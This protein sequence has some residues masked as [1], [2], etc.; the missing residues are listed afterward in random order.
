LDAV[1]ESVGTFLINTNN[2]FLAASRQGGLPRPFT[3]PLYATRGTRQGYNARFVPYFDSSDH[4]TFVEGIIGVPAV[5]TINWD[6][7]YIHSTDDDL[8]QIDQTQLRRNIF[9]IGSI[10]YYLSRATEREIPALAAE[11]FA[12]GQRRLANDLKVALEILREGKAQAPESWKR[13]RAV[14]EQ[15]TLREQRALQSIVA[16]TPDRG[17]GVVASAPNDMLARTERREAELASDL[18]AAFRQLHG[19]APAP[20]TL[21][22]EEQAA[23]RK[24]PQNVA[25]IRD[26][27]DNRGQVNFRHNLHGLMEAEVYNFVDGRRSY[28]DI[29]KAVSA[30]AAA[31]GSWY[32]GTVTLKDVVGLLDAAVA[33]KAL[34]LK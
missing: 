14:I 4:M 3:R 34:T 6:D 33:S 9:L 28:Y 26:Y 12:Q 15:G 22:A 5:A 24:V 1:F 8:F 31:A 18:E 11:T 30:E 21:T 20:I 13:A 16:F 27:F 29:Y 2:G 10:A 32:Y 19:R 7:D 23:A 17:R 25:S